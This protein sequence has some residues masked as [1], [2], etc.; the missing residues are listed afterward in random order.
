M[1]LWLACIP[2]RTFSVAAELDADCL[3][4]HD[5]SWT[6]QHFYFACLQRGSHINNQLHRAMLATLHTACRTTIHVGGFVPGALPKCLTASR[7]FLGPLSKH[8]L[9][10]VGAKRASWSK[11]RH[12]PPACTQTQSLKPTPGVRT[13]L[14]YGSSKSYSLAA[15]PRTLWT[16]SVRH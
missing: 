6:D 2:P 14:I 4:P 10:P 15:Y 12:S 11:V 8:V 1:G 13:K 5:L 3:T 16:C 7:A 9:A